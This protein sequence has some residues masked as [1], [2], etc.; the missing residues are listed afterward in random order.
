[1][2]I[3]TFPQKKVKKI[4]VTSQM[5]RIMRGIMSCHTGRPLLV[6]SGSSRLGKTTTAL[7]MTKEINNSYNPDNPDAFRAHHYEVGEI[8]AWS[9]NEQKKGIR[10]LYHE[11][12]NRLDEATYRELPAEALAKQLVYGLQ[13]K[14]IEMIFVDEAGNLS[15]EAIRG[16]VLVRDV[17][18]NMGYHLTI[19]FVGMDDLP[20]KLCS[21]RQIEGRIHKWFYFE[22]YTEKQL[23]S[24]LKELHP[25]FAQLDPQNI[26]HWEQIQYIHKKFGGIPGEVIPFINQVDHWSQQFNRIIDYELLVSVYD[27]LLLP[28]QTSIAESKKNWIKPKKDDDKSPKSKKN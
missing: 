26:K 11:C 28:K 12:I 13:R 25:H 14:K 20:I 23:F 10:S 1:M 8:A 22:E 3:L 18:E 6:I 17:A 5:K 4:I 7:K 2:S 15:Q 19:V 27:S 24:L 16:M 9:G 21:T